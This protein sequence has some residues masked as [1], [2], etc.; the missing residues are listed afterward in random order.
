VRRELRHHHTTPIFSSFVYCL[1][2]PFLSRRPEIL[3]LKGEYYIWAKKT[4][5]FEQCNQERKMSGGKK[6]NGKSAIII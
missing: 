6:E 2:I 3:F 5:K 4:R 1:F